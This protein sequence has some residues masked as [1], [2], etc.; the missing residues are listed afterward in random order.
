MDTH[1]PSGGCLTRMLQLHGVKPAL[2]IHTVLCGI[3]LRGNIDLLSDTHCNNKLI[4]IDHQGSGRKF[5]LIGGFI[6][7]LTLAN[8]NYKNLFMDS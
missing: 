1:L 8:R 7:V 2:W 3:F 5:C 6:V 4:Q